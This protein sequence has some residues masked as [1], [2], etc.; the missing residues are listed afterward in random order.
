MIR[1]W[2]ALIVGCPRSDKRRASSSAQG[3]AGN[4]YRVRSRRANTS[5]GMDNGCT[6]RSRRSTRA[7]LDLPRISVGSAFSRTL[8]A[9]SC[10]AATETVANTFVL[11]GTVLLTSKP[12]NAS[13]QTEQQQGEVSLAEQPGHAPP[14]TV[15][16]LSSHSSIWDLVAS[17]AGGSSAAAAWPADGR[18]CWSSPQHCAMR[19]RTDA[20][21]SAGTAGLR[22]SSTRCFARADPSHSAKGSAP[23]NA[24]QTVMPRE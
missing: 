15:F 13:V 12:C 18:E 7:R 6:T 9:A 19:V 24:S 21:H 22:P 20:G 10:I 1:D 11:G 17:A 4:A 3:A 23:A 16:S 8:D 5:D 14:D 2:A